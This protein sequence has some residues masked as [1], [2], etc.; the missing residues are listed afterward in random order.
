[1]FTVVEDSFGDINNDNQKFAEVVNLYSK[2]Y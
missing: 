1:M 2:T